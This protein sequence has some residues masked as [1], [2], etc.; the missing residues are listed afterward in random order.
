MK[1][2][3]HITSVERRAGLDHR[4]FVEHYLKKNIPV[5]ISDANHD[6]RAHQ[7]WSP[8]FFKDLYGNQIVK[9]MQQEMPMSAFMD[10]VIE[11]T[12]Q[13]PSPYLNEVN[14]HKDLPE[15]VEYVQPFLRYALPDRLMTKFIPASWGYRDGVVELLIAGQGTKFPVIHYDGFFMNTFVTQIRGD[16]EFILYPPDQTPYMYPERPGSNL[17]QVNDADEP[18]LNKFP[19]FAKARSVRVIVKQGE[20]IFMPTGWWHTTRILSLSIAVSTNNVCKD[21]WN[22]FVNDFSSHLNTSSAR[23]NVYRSYL[24]L[25]GKIMDIQGD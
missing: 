7:E 5:I 14:L 16:K 4:E 10:L 8:Q 6:W 13:N 11:G 9:V 15:L 1:S 23:R 25:A 21:Q 18:D 2:F 12:A 17:S 22:D 20:T 19:L 3:D 24:K